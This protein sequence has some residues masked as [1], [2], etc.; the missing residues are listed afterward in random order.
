MNRPPEHWIETL[1][2]RAFG[3]SVAKQEISR[4]SRTPYRGDTFGSDPRPLRNVQGQRRE[5]VSPVAAKPG[6][7]D[8][9][10]QIAALS[11]SLADRVDGVIFDVGLGVRPVQRERL[12]SPRR[13]ATV[14]RTTEG[15]SSENSPR[16]PPL[17][18]GAQW[19]PEFCV[20]VAS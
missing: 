17:C 12:L 10:N 15:E 11:Y 4:G 1:R 3:S 8:I 16:P 9:A 6:V 2:S 20:E 14:A 18:R 7:S 19:L 13:V 5:H